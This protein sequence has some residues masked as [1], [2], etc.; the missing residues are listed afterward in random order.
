M[1]NLVEDVAR[2]ISAVSL[3]DFLSDMLPDI[4][5]CKAT[6]ERELVA[7]RTG[8]LSLHSASQLFRRGMEGLIWSSLEVA[9]ANHIDSLVTQLQLRQIP[10]TSVGRRVDISFEDPLV[11]INIPLLLNLTPRVETVTVK[12][13]YPISL[14]VLRPTGPPLPISVGFV[15][16]LGVAAKLVC[17]QFTSLDCGP[18]LRDVYWLAEHL[19]QLTHFELVVTGYKPEDPCETGC[20]YSSRH[21]HA[22]FFPNVKYIA[23]GPRK[24]M[25]FIDWHYTEDLDEIMTTLCL[26]QHAP[27]LTSVDLREH[28][29][30]TPSFLRLKGGPLRHLGLYA[31]DDVVE[32]ALLAKDCPNLDILCLTTHKEYEDGFIWSHPSVTEI[33]I[34]NTHP[35]LASTGSFA[36]S[37]DDLASL[38]RTCLSGTMPSLKTIS[39]R[40]HGIVDDGERGEFVANAIMQA[41]AARSTFSLSPTPA[42]Q[43]I[44]L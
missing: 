2:L 6:M 23:L 22:V 9:N 28:I 1:D 39:L 34:D 10:Q 35:I 33:I 4:R 21:P 40:N 31:D 7:R 32:M 13:Q 8:I 14:P 30:A 25:P 19:P 43:I 36:G 27:S 29:I 12:H 41:T 37:R 11:F 44:W 26:P 24:G 17:L 15:Q 5:T 20:S 18:A 38:L 3:D 16:S 42:V